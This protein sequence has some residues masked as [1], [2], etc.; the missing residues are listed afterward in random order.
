MSIATTLPARLRP[1]WTEIESGERRLAEA[2][3]AG[4][5]A[6]LEPM[7]ARR[8]AMIL[9]FFAEL[10]AEPG[11]EVIRLELLRALIARNEALLGDSRMRLGEVADSSVQATRNRRALDAYGGQRA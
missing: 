1:G 7:A 5:Y 4:D 6:A 3:A 11:S 9:A 8:H 10:S 2:L